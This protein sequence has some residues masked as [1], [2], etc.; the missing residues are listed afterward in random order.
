MT[1]DAPGHASAE[2]FR[3]FFDRSLDLHDIVDM[4]GN[5]LEANRTWQELLG[6][7]PGELKGTNVM[8]LVHPDDRD[9][10]FREL[11]A[12]QQGS[13]TIWFDC[14]MRARDGR[15]RWFQWSV[16]ADDG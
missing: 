4:E 2:R 16:V 12:L 7:D 9:S 6:H 8:D 3:R 11:E 10:A 1:E 15:Y 14:R 13:D 5:F